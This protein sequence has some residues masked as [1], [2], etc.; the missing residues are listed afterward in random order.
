MRWMTDYAAAEEAGMAITITEQHLSNPRQQLF[1]LI[2][3]GVDESGRTEPRLGS[4]LE[5][6]HYSDGLGL[7]QPGTP[8]NNTRAARSGYSPEDD[9]TSARLR[10]TDA[11][12]TPPP[13]PPAG[14]AVERLGGALGLA[15]TTRALLAADAG[16]GQIDRQAD[17]NAAVWASSWGYFLAHVLD[18]VPPA[19]IR[20]VRRH[21][22]DHVRAGGALPSL[23][24]GDQPYGVLPVM[25]LKHFAN[26]E[27]GA[28]DAALIALLRKALPAWLMASHR[29]TVGT[30]YGAWDGRRESP[31]DRYFRLLA[32]QDA[33]VGHEGRSALGPEYIGNLWRFLQLDFDS[34]WR[35]APR[36]AANRLL[37]ELGLPLD[38]R[39]SGA[40][41]AGDA[42]PVPGP[43]VGAQPAAYLAELMALFG[44]PEDLRDAA[45]RGDTPL[46]Y[47]IVR[48]SALQE[49]WAGVLSLRNGDRR[50]VEEE[51]VDVDPGVPPTMTLWRALAEQ[52]P[53]GDGGA[54][55]S[56]EDYLARPD[57]PDAADMREFRQRITALANAV[58]TGEQSGDDL[59][60]MLR[61]SLDL[62]AHRLDAWISSFA[63][64]RL[65]YLRAP[66]RNP[67]GLI[68]GGFGWLSNVYPA[69][70]TPV[71]QPPQDEPAP[72]YADPGN[73]GLVIAPSVAQATTA[74]VLHAG[75]VARGGR[76]DKPGASPS[77]LASERV[78]LGE[79]LLDGVARRPAA[80]RAAR[81]PLRARPAERG[82]GAVP[83]FARAARRLRAQTLERAR[84][85]PRGELAEASVGRRR[86]R[87][88]VRRLHARRGPGGLRS[89]D[90]DRSIR[91]VRLPREER[92]VARAVRALLLELRRS[93]AVDALG[94]ALLAEGVHQ[95]WRQPDARGRRASTRSRT[96][97]APPPELEVVR[98][99]RTGARSTATGCCTSLDLTAAR[100]AASPTGGRQRAR[101][102]EPALNALGRASM[103]GD[104]ARVRCHGTWQRDGEVVAAVEVTLDELRLSPLDARRA[105]ARRRRLADAAPRAARAAGHAARADGADEVMPVRRLRPPAVRGRA[106]R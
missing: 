18:G 96:G 29:D 63:N 53:R 76:A 11:T 22:V 55:I 101:A 20:A 36:D 3:Y 90:A 21:F 49:W 37:R 82:A 84:R 105:R 12:R 9:A 6:H 94:D 19:A 32:T 98:T 7:A 40:V 16:A 38:Q 52:V 62:A 4:L 5:A 89:S 80:E 23:R 45:E 88:C 104:P 25:S 71:A 59:D 74:A 78:R 70:L 99:P 60:R 30:L 54:L 102:A 87:A 51:L 28:F 95:P 64:R 27:G 56:V 93:T 1:Q 58:A 15:A 77:N 17:M 65:A 13:P 10:A 34:G 73:A 26:R 68:C 106:T 61:G 66:Q 24:I 92:P 85:A 69:D 100:T 91:A 97:E 47:R 41:F 50:Y 2:V 31:R 39:H 103:L 67:A 83:A 42:Y 43:V 8:T 57:A 48:H 75:Y 79:Y 81:L 72:V 46:L 33:A 35:T 14:G 44:A 86:R